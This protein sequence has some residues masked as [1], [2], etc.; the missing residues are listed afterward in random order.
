MRLL[1]SV[2]NAVEAAAA[3]A[4][5]ADIVDAKEPRNGA[6]GAVSP[7]MLLSITAALAGAM[8]VS[9]ALGDAGR[10]D[11]TG[12]ARTAGAAGAAFVKIG[13]AG[14]RLKREMA[15][16]ATAARAAA[17]PAAV[18]LVA[19][20]DHER[21]DAAAPAELVTVADRTGAAWIL[22]DTYDK[23]TA[24]LT[25]LMTADALRTFVGRAKS[26]GQVVALAGQLTL[27][28]IETIHGAGADIVGLRGAACDDG[29]H[30]TVTVAR[31]R[32][33]RRHIDQLLGVRMV[34]PRFARALDG[35]S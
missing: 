27:D 33:L 15:E 17:S 11:V 6:L 16:H 5:G 32:A 9:V 29:R 26:L 23:T 3:L 25:Q 7:R 30:G 2:R 20:A 1:V 24:G 18:I 14:I 4:G 10:D 35:R 28:D 34:E 19:Y 13:F 8:P 12:A 21:A 31:V 22:L